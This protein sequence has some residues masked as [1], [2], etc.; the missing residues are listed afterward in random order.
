MRSLPVAE[1]LKFNRL[2]DIS[3]PVKSTSAVFPG[4]TPFKRELVVSYEKSRVINLTALTMSPHIGTHVDAP[5]HIKG[6]MTVAAELVGNLPLE[7]FIGAAL[8]LDLAPHS[9]CIDF[10]CIK[11]KLEKRKA[12]G[13]SLPERVLFKTM[14]KIRYEVF[15]ESY[16]Y[17]GT[18]LVDE[19]NERGVRLMGIDAPSA[20]HIES[21][22]LEAHHKLDSYGM[23][24]LENLD[25]CQ[26][27]EGDYTLIAFPIKFTELEA[28]PVRAVL[29]A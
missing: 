15:E 2:I 29:L 10:S 5:S 17:F 1:M 22:N 13:K 21:K 18:D 20:D 3:Q 9:S 26:V 7:P 8:V 12:S 16:A 19:L 25:L 4:D 6:D 11:A 28:A 24:W 27:E 14:N 23:T